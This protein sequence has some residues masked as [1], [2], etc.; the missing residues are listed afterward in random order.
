MWPNQHA[1]APMRVV[2]SKTGVSLVGCWFRPRTRVAQ[3]EHPQQLRTSHFPRGRKTVPFARR[4][5]RWGFTLIELLVVI[6]IIAILAA[7]LLPSL[8]KAKQKAV[9]V[10]C[11]SNLKQW[12]I[13]WMLYADDHSGSFSQGYTVGWARGEWVKALQDYYKQ[14]PYLLFCPDAKMRRGPGARKVLVPLTASSAVEYGGPHSCYDFPL[15]DPTLGRAKLLLSSY[16]INNWVYNPPPGVSE[17]QGRPTQWNWRTFS[18][19]H[20]TEVPLFADSMWRGG[21]P[22]HTD[23]LPAFNGEWAGADAESHHFAIA[24]HR[25]GIDLAF[26]D[27]SVRYSRAKDLWRLRWH[28][29]YDVN[30][31]SRIKFP[32]WM[33]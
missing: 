25:K 11:I 24:R 21:G 17:I 31:Y 14:K 27:G 22:R 4:H 1:A 32:A 5:V 7:M 30:Y 6:A 18:V 10:N 16:G 23:R 33:D 19:P 29:E 26:F 28:R 8:S 13:S 3:P 12:G 15:D 9:E 2:H 20:P